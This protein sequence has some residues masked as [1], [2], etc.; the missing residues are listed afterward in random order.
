M[1]TLLGALLGLGN[2]ASNSELIV[3]RASGLSLARLAGS[4]LMSG[5]ALMAVGTLVGEYI[6]PPMDRYARQFRTLAKHE[7]IEL[8]G[9]EGA[10]V[11]EGN[12]YIYVSG[13][14]QDFRFGGVFVFKADE[15]GW[16]ESIGRADAADVDESDRWVL[17]NLAETRFS[18]ERISRRLVPRESQRNNLNPELLNLT[19]MRPESL[20]GVQLYRYID[21]LK[22]NGLDALRWEVAFWNR[23]SSA[24]AIAIMCVLALPFVFGPLRSTGA[25]ARMVVGVL[26]GVAYFLASRS[27]ADGGQVYRLNSALVAWLP[28]AGLLL[29]TS[30]A[31]LRAR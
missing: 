9:G 25:G 13:F 21:Y 19:A 23:L 22:A 27:L 3:L 29:V 11:R 10:W 6:S 30:I 4:C 7:K 26:V 17:T 24:L 8:A 5:I 15:D 14:A 12:S 31:L 28:T 20:D 18:D 16:L 2:L 1:A